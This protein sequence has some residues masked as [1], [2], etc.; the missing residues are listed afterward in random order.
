M[1]IYCHSMKNIQGGWS[2]I[3]GTLMNTL[4]LFC[5]SFDFLNSKARIEFGETFTS[6]LKLT[7]DGT[8]IL[9]PQPTDD[10]RDPQNVC[11]SL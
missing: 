4:L 7:D 11:V 5:L 10:P 6:K 1:W 8:T 2:S 3:P 9:W